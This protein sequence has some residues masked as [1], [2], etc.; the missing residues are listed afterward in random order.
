[1]VELEN[2]FSLIHRAL[3]V[4][5]K[6]LTS[7]T[8]S[9]NSLVTNKT[10]GASTL[11]QNCLS[12]H[13]LHAPIGQACRGEKVSL[14]LRVWVF[15]IGLKHF[16]FQRGRTKRFSDYFFSSIL[17]FHFTFCNPPIFCTFTWIFD[18]TQYWNS[19]SHENW[20]WKVKVVSVWPCIAAFVCVCVCD[21]L[22]F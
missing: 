21:L 1:M 11:C 15:W 14:C 2:Q 6:D 5:F 19:D 7:L 3:Y 9:M 18:E 8:L 22:L 16:S 17:H 4:F 20:I 13:P 12:S 10:K